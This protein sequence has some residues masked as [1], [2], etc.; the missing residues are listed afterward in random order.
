LAKGAAEKARGRGG[1][2]GGAAATAARRGN[3]GRRKGWRAHLAHF[4][5]GTVCAL[6]GAKFGVRREERKV[7]ASVG[8]AS[9]EAAAEEED[10]SEASESDEV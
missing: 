3:G 7:D 8:V 1:G 5:V 9:A 2:G 10:A 6:V 4:L